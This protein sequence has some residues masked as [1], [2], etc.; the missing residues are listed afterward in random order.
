MPGFGP[1]SRAVTDARPGLV[2]AGI[3]LVYLPPHSPEL[4]LIEGL[5][6]HVKHEELPARSYPTVQ[7]LQAAADQALDQHVAL[8]TH[9]AEELLEAA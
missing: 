9:C 8:P 6:R 4:N 7:A 3:E 5:W 2:A 1:G